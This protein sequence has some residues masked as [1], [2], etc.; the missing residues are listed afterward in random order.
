MVEPTGV[1]ARMAMRIPKAAQ[2]VDS[3][4]EHMVTERKLLKT[5]MAERAGKITRAEIK[6]DP[7]R[8]IARTITTATVTAISRLYRSAAV[9]RALAKLSSKVTA[10]IL[11]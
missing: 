3:T 6:R 1:P 4:A 5:L 11:L 10:K 8:F 2:T 7:T 9:P